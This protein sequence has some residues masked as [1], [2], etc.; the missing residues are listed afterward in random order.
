VVR[1]IG[2]GSYS[3]RF[4]HILG[5]IKLFADVVKNI[6][7]A[8][9]GLIERGL[10]GCER[11]QSL[12]KIGGVGGHVFAHIRCSCDQTQ[13]VETLNEMVEMLCQ[14]E[15]HVRGDD[16]FDR[17]GQQFCFRG[18]VTLEFE[19]CQPSDLAIVCPSSYKVGHQIGLSTGG[20]GS[21]V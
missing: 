11:C 13:R 6:I 20:S 19:A 12:C 3:P 9:E 8:R 18:S 4:W 16:I 2:D 5:K 17:C 14:A 10:I 21:F 15:D 1:G 7:P